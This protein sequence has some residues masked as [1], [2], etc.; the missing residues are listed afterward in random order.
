MKWMYAAIGSATES[1]ARAVDCAI[2][3]LEDIGIN[4]M[5]LCPIAQKY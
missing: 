5:L 3:Q 4:E 2:S 1:F